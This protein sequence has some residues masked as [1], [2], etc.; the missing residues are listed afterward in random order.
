MFVIKMSHQCAGITTKNVPCKRMIPLS[1]KYCYSH[2]DQGKN[3]V[4]IIAK[5]QTPI[6]V[7]TAVPPRVIIPIRVTI[8]ATPKVP[9]V[10][11][12]ASPPRIPTVPR[13]TS[14]VRA[15]SPV[16]PQVYPV[17]FNRLPVTEPVDPKYGKIEIDFDGENYSTNVPADAYRTAY[18]PIGQEKRVEIGL[19][20]KFGGSVPF[21]VEGEH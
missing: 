8:P 7:P 2:V 13:V 3:P 12:V 16:R 21:F 5:P 9:T 14:P 15:R 20:Q 17:L 11:R 6:R 18:I 10:P 1:E 4:T 19:E